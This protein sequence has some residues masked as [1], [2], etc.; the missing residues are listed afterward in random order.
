MGR[1]LSARSSS[2]RMLTIHQRVPS[3]FSRGVA[4]FVAAEDLR[5]VS[6]GFDAVHDG[7]FEKSMLQ[8]VAARAFGVVLDSHGPYPGG[9]IRILGG[10]GEARLRQK[11]RAEAVPVAF[12]GGPGD[13]AVERG[14]NAVDRLH[15]FGAGGRNAGRGGN[16]CRR[17]LLGSRRFF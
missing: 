15:V 4:G 9:A 6:E 13:Y 14:Q 11:Q 16:L 8:E 12:A 2:H 5:N 7:T 3:L 1:G 17:L 10:S